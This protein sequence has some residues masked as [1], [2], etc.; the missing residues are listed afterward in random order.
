MS[1]PAPLTP[2][3]SD[4]R[5]FPF[6]PLQ[7]ARLRDSGMAAE[8]A[9]E[10]CWYAVL[11]WAAAWHQLP[12]GSLPDNDAAL[13]RLAGLGR[14]AR[15]WRRHRD[16]ALRG[17]LLCSDGRLYHP[18]IAEQVHAA[19]AEKCAYRTRKEKRSAIAR[20]AAAVRWAGH[21]P[22]ADDASAMPDALP[23]ETGT[24]TETGR[25]AAD[26][27]ACAGEDPIAL[28][29]EL[30]RI[31]GVRHVEPAAIL[32]AQGVVR[33]WLAEGFDPVGEITPAIR[34]AVSA[35]RAERIS[36]LA[37]FDGPLR[38]LRARKEARD[39]GHRNTP[40][41]LRGPR[42][43][44]ALDMW[45]D[46]QRRLAADADEAGDAGDAGGPDGAAADP[47]ADLGTGA[48]LPPYLA[49]RHRGA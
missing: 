25:L 32:R 12:A 34:G 48:A 24:E 38:Q 41:A 15:T 17:F 37:Y 42:P 27:A 28:A 26:E 43:D 10:A 35:A 33:Q 23:K 11:L 39:H 29:A 14:D 49:D 3:D 22:S 9:P 8:I 30:C 36:S 44:P 1:T 16:A 20:K 45:R 40:A 21:A 5:S 47:G 19:W 2:A 4:L 18:V 7:V 46:A 13:M 6:M 31:A